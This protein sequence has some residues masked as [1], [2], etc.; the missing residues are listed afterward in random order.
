MAI[1]LSSS[2][3]DHPVFAWYS[4]ASTYDQNTYANGS[5]FRRELENASETTWVSAPGDLGFRTSVV[6]L[7]SALLNGLPF[8]A[9]L[10]FLRWRKSVRSKHGTADRLSI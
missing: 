5:V 7:P 2:T 1:V 3:P 8:S 9:G 4:W 10:L 6:P